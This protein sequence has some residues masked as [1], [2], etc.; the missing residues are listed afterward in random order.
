MKISLGVVMDPIESINI[1]KD[2]TFAMLLESQRRGWEIW[3]MQQKDL[4]LSENQASA[5]MQNLSVEDNPGNWFSLGQVRT[6]PLGTLDVI[7]MRKDP[8]FDME[9]V[10]TTYLLEN[11]EKN[12]CLVINSPSSLRDCNEK[13]FTSW[14]PQCCPETLVSRN[15]EQVLSFVNKYHEA[16]I[17]PLGGMGGASIFRAHEGDPNLNVIIETLTGNGSRYTMAQRFIP[18]IRDGDKR[19]LMV[20]GEPVPYALARIPKPGENRGNLAVGGKGVGIPLS[21]RDRWIASQVAPVLRQKSILFA[22]L[23]VIGDY[24]TEINVT[25]PTC[26]REL[27]AQ[28][29]L[30]ISALLLD[31]ILEKLQ[32]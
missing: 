18:E 10:Y 25:S 12:G 15:H 29:N 24:L 28:F 4:F 31:S 6:V 5:R 17:K 11:A 2:S 16:I 32:K 7:L 13:L 1:K 22:G 30:N 14:F 9:Y 19:I 21:E 26:I 8:P 23:D 27:D 20:D 3:Y